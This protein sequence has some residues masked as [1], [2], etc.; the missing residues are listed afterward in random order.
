MKNCRARALISAALSLFI[1]PSLPAAE[2]PRLVE[3]EG[4][5]ALMVEGQPFLLLGAQ[6]NN[7]SAWPASLEEVWP[8]IEAIHANTLEAPVY[9][10]Q[11]EPQPGKFDFSNLEDLVRQARAHHVYL[12]LLWFGTWKNGKMHYVPEWVKSDLAQFPR[13]INRRGEPTDVLSPHA[14]SNLEADKKAFARL[15]QH[16]RQIDGDQHTVLLVQVE[17]ESGRIYLPEPPRSRRLA[18]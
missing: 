5:Y 2:M 1:G 18:A 14:T 9:W 17:N 16:L 6:M 7:S 10:E 11:L 8:A 4:R 12:V 13:V 15:M 3:H